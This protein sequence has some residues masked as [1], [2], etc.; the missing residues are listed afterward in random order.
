MVTLRPAFIPLVFSLFALLSLPV[1]QITA[2][3][4]PPAGRKA[5][6]ERAK[7]SPVVVSPEVLPDRRVI[8]RLYAPQAQV[9]RV[10]LDGGVSLTKGNNDVWEAMTGPL[11]PGAYRYT[12]TMDGAT[13]TDPRNI[14]ME[15]M[16]VIARSICMS[17]ALHSWIQRTFLAARFPL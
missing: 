12:F 15:R 3:A 13:V 8:V 17:L 1:F 14:E 4:P 10:S 9:V 6:P 11:D 16:Q 7:R 5:A 2:Q